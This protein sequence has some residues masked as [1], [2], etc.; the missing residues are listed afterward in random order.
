MSILSK[1]THLALAR[2]RKEQE[3]EKKLKKAARKAEK[4]T[5]N[6]N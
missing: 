4:S 1:K 3:L 5:K 2:L 6:E